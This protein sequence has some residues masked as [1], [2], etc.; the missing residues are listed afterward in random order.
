[1]VLLECVLRYR[2][3]ITIQK[4]D[5]IVVQISDLLQLVYLS[6]HYRIEARRSVI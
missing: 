1:M 5:L 3:L 4:G 2:M 6:D